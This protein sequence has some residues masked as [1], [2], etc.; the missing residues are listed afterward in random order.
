MKDTKE[1]LARANIS[2]EADVY[3]EDLSKRCNLGFEAGKV[4]KS[5]LAT[6][7]IQW[8]QSQEKEKHIT[9]IQQDHFDPLK[10]LEGIVKKMKSKKT[11]FM[12]HE[13]LTTALAPIAKL[14]RS[15]SVKRKK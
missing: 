13:D 2:R 6:W 4:T 3:L 15:H 1:A 14:D 9:I 12:N 11:K 10:H 5:S 7:I 8:F